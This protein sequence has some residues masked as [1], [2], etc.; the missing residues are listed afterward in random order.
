MPLQVGVVRIRF[1]FA[2]FALVRLLF[3]VG[4]N[5][6]RHAR[7]GPKR[8]PADSALARHFVV[9]DQLMYLQVGQPVE[10]FPASIAREL[11]LAVNFVHVP[12]QYVNIRKRLLANRALILRQSV[13]R[14]HSDRM[15]S[16]HVDLEGSQRE[17]E[18]LMAA[19][20]FVGNAFR[21]LCPRVALP[22]PFVMVELAV[23]GER[24]SAVG[25]FVVV[26]V[27][28]YVVVAL[29]SAQ[30]FRLADIA[31][32]GALGYSLDFQ[33]SRHDLAGLLGGN[34][35]GVGGVRRRDALVRNRPILQPL[36]DVDPE[37]EHFVGEV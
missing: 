7:R 33:D 8:F 1:V 14:F 24:L 6:Q 15:E 12:P 22:I 13:L 32:I 18:A 30:E 2:D 31:A 11:H 3:G 20:A 35:L 16:V 29:A 25:A 34:E 28:V 19:V 10:H 37:R 21:R 9:V 5:V 4:A 26:E 23:S 27:L 36:A 17:D